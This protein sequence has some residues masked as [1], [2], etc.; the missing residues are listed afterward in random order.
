MQLAQHCQPSV[1]IQPTTV[2][3]PST[4][5]ALKRANSAAINTSSNGD[6]KGGRGLMTGAGA[7]LRRSLTAVTELV[8]ADSARP[9][10]CWWQ[11]LR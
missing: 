2:A 9:R 10:C 11:Q 8:A 1:T 4:T 3:K 7:A 6:A 5:S